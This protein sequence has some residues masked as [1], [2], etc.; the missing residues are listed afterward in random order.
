[1]RLGIIVYTLCSVPFYS[2]PREGRGYVA[3]VPIFGPPSF[4]GSWLR[5]PPL[6]TG[7]DALHVA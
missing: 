2:G 7:E 4:V 6:G 5:S 1:M 3:N